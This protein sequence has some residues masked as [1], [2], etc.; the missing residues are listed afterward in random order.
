[1]GLKLKR[2]AKTGIYQIHGS[3]LGVRVRK[4][5]STTDRENAERLRSVIESNIFDAE[6]GKRH[7]TF[8]EAVEGYLNDTGNYRFMSKPFEYF[9]GW[10]LKAITP[11]E[12]RR[13]A[14]K[15]YPAAAGAT[16]NRQF[17]TPMQAVI[18]WAHQQGWCSPIKVR[19]FPVEKPERTTVDRAWMDAFMGSASPRVAAIYLFMHQTGARISEACRLDWS[20]VDFKTMT[21]LLR[22]TKNGEERLCHLT[23]ELAERM[24]SLETLG[25]V[26]GYTSRSSVYTPARRACKKAGIAYVPPHQAGRHSFATA[27]DAEGMTVPAIAKAGGW[28]SHSLVSERYA[29]P[30]EA[31]QRAAEIMG[32]KR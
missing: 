26:F 13:A 25:R 24:A 21:A 1:M 15:S 6:H 28:K 20:D 16:R 19:R 4:S 10:L 9:D 3:F 29:H 30:D 12:I 7:Y 11:V 8:A 22:K 23:T 5:A 32:R 2:D 31:G 18:N 17:I 27:L 14:E